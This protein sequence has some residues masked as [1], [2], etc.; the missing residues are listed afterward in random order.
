[1]IRKLFVKHPADTPT[2]KAQALFRN[3]R[4]PSPVDFAIWDALMLPKGKKTQIAAIKIANPGEAINN[5]FPLAASSCLILLSCTVSSIKLK[6]EIFPIGKRFF[7]HFFRF[8]GLCFEASK[9]H[10]PVLLPWLWDWW[11]IL[12]HFKVLIPLKMR[13]LGF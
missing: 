13:F 11:R 12:D 10:F 6:R 9:V 8:Q 2:S 3:S 4:S 1:M 5:H 7:F